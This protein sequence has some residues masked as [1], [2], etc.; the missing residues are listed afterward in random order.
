MR[1][2]PHLVKRGLA[3]LS[4][5]G[6]LEISPLGWGTLIEKIGLTGQQVAAAKRLFARTA[7]RV[8]FRHIKYKLVR[9][10][11]LH[12]IT[13]EYHPATYGDILSFLLNRF[14]DLKGKKICDL[15]YGHPEHLELFQEKGAEV[16]GI[17]AF[18]THYRRGMQLRKGS[19]MRLGELFPGEKFDVV[20]CKRTLERSGGGESLPPLKLAKAVFDSLKPGGYFIIQT[21]GMPT[22]TPNHLKKAGFGLVIDIPHTDDFVTVVAKKDSPL[23]SP[24]SKKK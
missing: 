13:Y 17:D 22:I 18:Q 1:K 11:R 21:L 5:A 19:I 7:C 24:I 8:G 14:K 3:K 12:P 23:P 9:G 16:F 4:P 20:I 10:G 2:T 6:K 15:G